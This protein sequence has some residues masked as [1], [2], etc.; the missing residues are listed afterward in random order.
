MCDLTQER[1]ALYLE[2]IM[3]E[4]YTILKLKLFFRLSV[5]STRPALWTRVR[6]Q[7]SSSSG[8]SSEGFYPPPSHIQAAPDPSAMS[9]SVTP[10]AV[11]G[12]QF[13][14]YRNI[15]GQSWWKSGL[16]AVW[17]HL[18]ESRT[19]PLFLLPSPSS[20]FR[21]FLFNLLISA[22]GRRWNSRTEKK[23]YLNK[24]PFTLK[25]VEVEK[26]QRKYFTTN[27]LFW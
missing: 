14:F 16:K 6:P 11:R 22:E 17:V 20:P 24:K 15:T 8:E 21:S 5:R 23:I 7:L 18:K 19:S 1:V 4:K 13:S 26:F 3:K 10:A 12:E 27:V 2:I 9:L 25:E